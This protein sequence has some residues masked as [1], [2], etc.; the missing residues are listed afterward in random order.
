MKNKDSG[1]KVSISDAMQ[2]L[3]QLETAYRNVRDAAGDII[4]GKCGYVPHET[5]SALGN[6][7][8]IVQGVQREIM[9]RVSCELDKD[10][11]E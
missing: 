5:L 3:A 11:G 1:R 9:F 8:S 4:S 2:V 6:A 7:E 10:S